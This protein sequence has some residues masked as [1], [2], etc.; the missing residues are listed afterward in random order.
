MKVLNICHLPLLLLSFL[1]FPAH[2]LQS[3]SGTL[4]TKLAFNDHVACVYPNPMVLANIILYLLE[5]DQLASSYIGSRLVLLREVVSV[6][7]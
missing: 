1:S 6:E 5:V 7:G 4:N 3:P 2:F